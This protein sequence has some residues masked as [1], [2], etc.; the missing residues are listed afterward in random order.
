MLRAG[1]A[2]DRLGRRPC[3]RLADQRGVGFLAVLV[4]LLIVVALYVGYFGVPHTGGG[5][6]VGVQA[7]DASRAV[8]CRTQRQ[9]IERDLAAWTVAHSGEAPS[10]EALAEDGIRVPSCPGGGRYTLSGGVVSCSVHR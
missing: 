8:A 7:I 10:L 5:P 3:A 2:F 9:Q 4:A 1:S 6:T